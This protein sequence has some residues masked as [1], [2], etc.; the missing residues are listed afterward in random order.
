MVSHPLSM[1]FD[2]AAFSGAP[3]IGALTKSIMTS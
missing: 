2:K 1:T 3:K